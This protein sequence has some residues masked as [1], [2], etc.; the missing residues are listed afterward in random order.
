MAVG[1]V[2]VQVR[3]E[4]LDRLGQRRVVLKLHINHV[5]GDYLTHEPDRHPSIGAKSVV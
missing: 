2:H 1:Y 3:K 5:R 4:H